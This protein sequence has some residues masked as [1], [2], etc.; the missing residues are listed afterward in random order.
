VLETVAVG[1]VAWRYPLG[2]GGLVIVLAFA[3]LALGFRTIYSTSV[4]AVIRTVVVIAAIYVGLALHP[5]GLSRREPVVLLAGVLALAGILTSRL[6]AQRAAI[7]HFRE[8]TE[9]LSRDLATAKGRNDIYAAMMRAVLDLVHNRM[10]ARVIIWDE[11]D[12]ARPSAAAGANADQ[13]RT[14]GGQPLTAIAWIRDAL[15]A[16]KSI[17]TDSFNVDE[18]RSAIGFEPFHRDVFFVPLQHREEVRALSVGAGEP[19]PARVRESIESVARAGEVALGSIELTREGMQGL[20]ERSYSDPGTGVVNREA[21]RQRL[22]QILEQPDRLVAVL[23]IRIDRFRLI[24]DSIGSVAGGDPLAVLNARLEGAV[25]G[26]CMI[27]RFAGDDFAVALDGLADRA[28]AEQAAARIRAALDEPLPG[29]L[30]S[31]AGVFVHSSVGVAVSGPDG[32]TAADLLRNADV[33]VHLAQ[34]AGGGNCRMFDPT[35]RASIV[36]RLE[37]E[38]DLARA[39]DNHEFEMHYQPSVQLRDW[40]TVSG[41]EALIRWNHPKRGMVPPGQFISAAEETG[42]ITQIG[43]W[44]LREGCCQQRAW[45]A[46]GRDLARLTV[47]VNLSPVQFGQPDPAGMIHNVLA[48]TGVDPARMVIELTESALVENSDCNRDKLHAIKGTGV[49]LAL[50]D[51][52]T[53]FSSLSYLR[54][55]PFDIIKIDRSF[56]SEVDVDEGAAALARSVI[57]MGKALGLTSLAEGIETIGQAEW[58]TKAGC[59]AAQGFF[60]AR[61]APPDQLLPL[62]TDGLPVPASHG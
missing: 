46:A 33:A 50:D 48:E 56:V 38:S 43:E 17:Y 30:G 39:L 60:F 29:V 28:A 31:G 44:V 7:A 35:M 8:I 18:L 26:G 49:R 32:R 12:S 10:G 25:P 53:G 19:I 54:Q 61:P 14:E 20:R 58:L 57:A 27:A 62:L 34:A 6:V 11:P 59:D 22:D 3:L 47:S 16:G 2:N 51:F 1:V 23:L 24:G 41:V 5:A 15:V 37:L 40:G 45:A 9:Q 4:R 52:G 21:L 42:L 36:D 13:V 55:F